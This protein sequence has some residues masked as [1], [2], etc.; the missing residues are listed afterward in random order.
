[1]CFVKSYNPDIFNILYRLLKY[2]CNISCDEYPITVEYY[3]DLI[4]FHSGQVV[5]SPSGRR[6]GGCVS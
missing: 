4:G 3:Y 2:G 5:S 1:M 6:N